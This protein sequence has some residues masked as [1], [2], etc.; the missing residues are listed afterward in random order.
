MTSPW[1]LSPDATVKTH[2]AKASQ[3]TTESSKWRPQL[4]ARIDEGVVAQTSSDTLQQHP[5]QREQGNEET[6]MTP[7]G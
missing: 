3:R 7:R 1:L 4:A 2:Y 6:T 5:H